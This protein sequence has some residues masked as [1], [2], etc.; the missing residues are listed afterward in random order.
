VTALRLIGVL[1]GA[2]V[3]GPWAGSIGRRRG[4]SFWFGYPFGLVIGP[5]GVA[6]VRFLPRG[7]RP[8]EQP[9]TPAPI[10]DTAGWDQLV[11]AAA[12]LPV[13]QQEWVRSDLAGRQERGQ[14]MAAVIG[15][16]V[17]QPDDPGE[18]AALLIYPHVIVAASGQSA[19]YLRPGGSQVVDAVVEEA[20]LEEVTSNTVHIIELG[21][22]R[23][24]SAALAALRSLSWVKLRELHPNAGM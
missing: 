3:W 21:P 20:G 19:S 17:R 14:L 7:S 5:I 18:P 2:V 8:L 1:I 6:I 23:Q 11:A 12:T 24:Q 15:R 13:D 4:H 16:R 10:Y 9:E 22:P